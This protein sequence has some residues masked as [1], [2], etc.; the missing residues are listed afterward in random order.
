MADPS[1]VERALARRAIADHAIEQLAADLRT[2]LKAAARELR[3]FPLFPESTTQA[4]EAEPGAAAK[5]EYGC[6]V[7]LPDGELY[8]F[9]MAMNFSPDMPGDISKAEDTREMRFAPQDYIPYA[10]TALRE[11]TRQL[12][13]RAE[14]GARV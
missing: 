1:Q 6:V 4:I 7:V 14:G 9:T 8:E 12:V 5:A 2:S 13:Q 3:P 10:Y 11:I